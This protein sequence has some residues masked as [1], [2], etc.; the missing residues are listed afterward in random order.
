MFDSNLLSVKIKANL[1]FGP[2]THILIGLW[3]P[4]LALISN[5][6]VIS[7]NGV[8]VNEDVYN[9]ASI[10]AQVSDQLHESAMG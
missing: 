5:F 9:R 7:V 4:E 10:A 6:K 1:Q 8:P 3:S 2:R